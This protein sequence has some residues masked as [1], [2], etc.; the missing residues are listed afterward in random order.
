VTIRAKLYAAI[1][2][3]VI[4]PVVTIGVALA[5]FA[6]LGDRF[7]DVAGAA[8][9]Q[10]L[11]LELKFAVTDMN[12]WQTAYGYDAG[13]SR[14]VFVRSAATTKRL[15]DRSRAALTSPRDRAPLARLS[16]AYDEFMA[17]D[18]RAFA[19]LQAGRAGVTKRLFLGPEIAHFQTM[20]SAAAALAAEQDR[21]VR[22]ASRDF[23]DARR[24]ARREL[25]AVAIG[26]GVVIVLLLITVQDVVRLAL[27]R[28]GEQP[29]G[30]ATA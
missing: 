5:A 20:A 9:R 26:A 14:P 16:A 18:R 25:V 29:G 13:R 15:I 19:A 8:S 30:Q 3:T 4:G 21:R 12:G 27:E 17:L 11:A 22:Q 7:D 10:S 2:L 6:T 24:D 23:A 1:V 28:R